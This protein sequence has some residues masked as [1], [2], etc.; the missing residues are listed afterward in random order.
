MK[1]HCV[2]MARTWLLRVAV[3]VLVGLAFIPLTAEASINSVTVNSS[4]DFQA[5]HGY[6]YAEITIHGSVPR[7]DGTVGHYSVP[8]V[9]IYPRH[10]RGNG[11]GVVDWLNLRLPHVASAVHGRVAGAPLGRYASRWQYVRRVTRAVNH[12]AA[13][14]YI[15]NKDRMALIAA[16]QH[17]PLPAW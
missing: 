15:S 12:L 8:A 13:N 14:G 7:T 17:E 2:S 5:A 10:R 4:G 3:S 9:L 6:T 16:A 1:C 11:V